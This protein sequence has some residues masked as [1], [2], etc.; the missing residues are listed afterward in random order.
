MQLRAVIISRCIFCCL[1]A[2][3]SASWGQKLE[4]K[5]SSNPI[6]MGQR[7]QVTFTCNEQMSSFSPPAF[8]GFQ[9]LSGPNQS[10]RHQYVNGRSS[11]SI[12]FSYYLAP[13]KEGEL[14]I[15]SASAK[16]GG[17]TISSQ[18]ITLSVGKGAAANQPGKQVAKTKT[19]QPKN[20][21]VFLQA[22][23]NK[24]KVYQGEELSVT[25]T[26]YFRANIVRNEVSKLPAL[27]GFWAQDVKMPE[28]AKVY[29]VNLNGVRYQAADLKKTIVFPQ[30]SGD[31]EID[32]MEF[33]CVIRKRSN[34][35]SHGFFNDIFG[36]YKEEKHFVKSKN[37]KIQVLPLPEAG[38]P[39]D[40][41]GA[42]GQFQLNSTIDKEQLMANDAVTLKTTLSGSGN[43]KLVEPVRPVFPPDI[44]VYDP[45]V[46]EHISTKVLG[47][48]GSKTFEYLLVPRHAGNYEI[49]AFR[50][51]YF[52]PKKKVYRSLESQ[53]YTLAVE[54]GEETGLSS[55]SAIAKEDLQFIGTDI[56]FIKTVPFQ[57]KKMG[58]TFFLSVPFLSLYGAPFLLL[59]IF[60]ILRK[61]KLE[62]GRNLVLVKRKRATRLARKRFSAAKVAMQGSNR[63]EFFEAVLKGLW[64][65]A[66]DKLNV[67]VADLSKDFVGK[68]LHEK[69]VDQEVVS[70]FMGMLDKIEFARY[71]PPNEEGEME[72]VYSGAIEILQK[73]EGQLK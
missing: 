40:F 56:L 45:K 31:L 51:S 17:K 18:P 59:I 25:Y 19:I 36:S 2:F 8:E 28:Q 60:V 1:F 15:G 21:D 46:I 68:S 24:T 13:L 53:A 70:G 37:I 4:A 62:E 14:T 52:D 66:S 22:T 23:A 43:L 34:R 67:D 44:E 55:V 12:S 30:R 5:V 9:V 50:F 29:S 26:I 47:V 3:S 72:M 61:R 64:G 38:K 27:N 35:H 11:I 20:K 33:T 69:G 41:N 10:S 58:S 16:A 49:P 65:Y 48:T 7:V 57:L 32:P 71:A 63:Q 39:P 6:K 42:V 73:L 54:R